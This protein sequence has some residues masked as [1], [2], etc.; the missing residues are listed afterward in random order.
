MFF[1]TKLNKA[2]VTWF[3]CGKVPVAPG[4]MGSIGAL[5]L[6][7]VLSDNTALSFRIVV[8]SG[9]TAIAILSSAQDQETTGTRDPSYV[10]VDEVA[11]MLWS[12]LLIPAGATVM[13]AA[14]V[15]F[16]IFD[17]LKP[18]PASFFDRKSKTAV[19][20]IDRGAYIVLDDVVAGLFTALVLQGLISYG[21]FPV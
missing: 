2:I 4:T 13:A 21:W 12:T 8:A 17:V 16:R 14:F 5:P 6:C 10:V 1:P 15:L 20:S 19:K 18:F 7:W 9:M 11:G 3:G